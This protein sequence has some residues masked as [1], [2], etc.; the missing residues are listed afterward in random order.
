MN[1]DIFGIVF[2]VFVFILCAIGA[3]AVSLL[4]FIFIIL[5]I[6]SN[7]NYLTIIQYVENLNSTDAEAIF[8]KNL[9]LFNINYSTSNDYEYKELCNN[10]I[11]RFFSLFDSVSYKDNIY[12]KN[13]TLEYDE[14]SDINYVRIGS[15]NN[16][17][18]GILLNIHDEVDPEHGVFIVD[19]I[20]KDFVIN[21]LFDKYSKISDIK[22]LQELLLIEKS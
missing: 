18:C 20:Y 15:A 13:L 1:D 5:S 10:N 22:K 9:E 14:Y 16:T 21:I 4:I 2:V 12:S 11:Q 7:K 3:C 17:P 8:N 6:P 19:D